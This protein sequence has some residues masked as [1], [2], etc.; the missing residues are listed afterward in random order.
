MSKKELENEITKKEKEEIKNDFIKEIKKDLNEDFKEK[1]KNDIIKEIR[2]EAN[3][4]VKDD[5]KEQLIIDVNNEIK[6][7][8]R[9]EQRK[10]IRQKSFKIFKKNIIILILIAIVAYFSYCLWDARYFKFMK[11]KTIVEKVVKEENNEE[12]KEI[13]IIKDKS[14]YIENYGYLLDNMKLSLPMDN[15]NIYYLF[16][17]NYNITNIK[18]TI[19]LNLAYKFVE[20]KSENE[21]SY[22]I[23]EDEMKKAYFKFFGTNDNYNP[24]SFTVDCMQYY[25]NEYEKIFVAYKFTCDSSNPFHIKQEIKDMYEENGNIIIE[26]VMGVYNDYNYLFNYMNLY[27]AIATDF[28]GSKSILDYEANLNTYKYTFKKLEN[29]YYFDSIEKI[30]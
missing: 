29:D 28:D 11:D 12:N 30:K 20:N 24:V 7:N 25:Y 18:D 6:D 23:S 1:F 27:N 3:T 10:L 5:I 14:W 4:V 2:Y 22:I 13:E 17:E 19:K 9:K 21:Y 15:S 16:N 8:I 26:T